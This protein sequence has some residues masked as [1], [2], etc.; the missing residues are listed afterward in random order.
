MQIASLPQRERLIELDSLR[1][2]AAINLVL[3][4]YTHV[5]AVKHG[6]VSELGWEFPWGKYGVQL[7]FMLS[8]FVNAMTLFR[9]PVSSAFVINRCARILPLFW[10]AMGL[11]LFW[12]SLPPLAESS[13][14]W[15]W[16]Q[17]LANL[18]VMPGLW[19][20][21]ALDPVTWTL[22]VEVLFYLQLL[23]ALRWRVLDKPLLLLGYVI[24]TGVL[25]RFIPSWESAEST[26]LLA[27]AAWLR[28]LFIW[29]YMPLF[30][31]GI[32]LERLRFGSGQR[33]T[34]IIGVAVCL[35]LF[36]LNDELGHNPIITLG[37][38]G[39]LGGAV[40]GWLPFLKFRPLVALSLCSYSL[41]LLHNN[42]GSVMIYQ[43][44]HAGCSAAM[45]IAIALGVILLL[46]YASWR[47]LEL[48]AAQQIK[49][50]WKSTGPAA[51]QSSHPSS[52]SPVTVVER[53]PE[54][55]TPSWGPNGGGTAASSTLPLR[56]PC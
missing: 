56:P 31:S 48:P 8:G 36:H 41:Y 11:N 27:V 7:F 33:T 6:F 4:H 51:A 28:E 50:W 26:G 35:G 20:Y 17:V 52:R 10:L 47:W 53:V 39:L 14:A 5:Y 30:A 29:E 44:N 13:P 34:A 23:V 46:A 24:A 55:G 19:G 2:L 45:S 1:A 3:F 9:Q 43:L 18:T 22:Q 15:D 54:S 38:L 49:R 42:L 32:F 40:W 16:S 37:L 21:A 12:L 25:L